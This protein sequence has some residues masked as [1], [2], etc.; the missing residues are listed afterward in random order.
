MSP[1]IPRSRKSALALAGAVAATITAASVAGAVN[2]GLLSSDPAPASSDQVQL[3][4]PIDA[5]AATPTTEAP[6]QV[7]VQDVYDLPPADGQTPA[8]TPT[9]AVATNPPVVGD[10][11]ATSFDD[12]SSGGSASDDAAY[13]DSESHD[14]ESHETESPETE[15]HDGEFEDD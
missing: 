2:L 13:E 7:V 6:V 1:M 3:F 9:A 12:H 5:T 10:D 11:G 14:T 8:T 15:S 4:E